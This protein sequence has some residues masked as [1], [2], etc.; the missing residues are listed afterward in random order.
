MNLSIRKK[1]M[2]ALA[3]MLLPLAVLAIAT[4]SVLDQAVDAVEEILVDPIA[5]IDKS[6]RLQ[7]LL[8][9]AEMPANDYLVHGRK[10]ERVEFEKLDRQVE[11]MFDTI[12]LSKGLKKDQRDYVNQA[13]KHWKNARGLSRKI[14]S[15]HTPV[16]NRAAANAMERMDSEFRNANLLMEK[17]HTIAQKELKKGTGL[18]AQVKSNLN[19]T[20]VLAFIFG[21]LAIAILVFLLA[22]SVL[23]P[24]ERLEQGVRAI[25]DGDYAKRVEVRSK[26][27]F[28]SLANAFNNMAAR[29]ATAY[30]NLEQLSLRDG[31]TGILNRRAL[32]DALASESARAMRFGEKYSL[33]MFDID[34][35][36]RV[37]DD[38]GHLFGDDVLIALTAAVDKQIRPVDQFGRYGGEEF[39]VIMPETDNK[40]AAKSAERL[41]KKIEMMKLKD[42]QGNTVPVSA[43]FGVAS[44]PGEA[45]SANELLELADKRLYFAKDSGRNKVVSEG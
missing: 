20:I 31:L 6:M 16:G 34:H 45:D 41:R 12:L 5:D 36:K 29:L 44:F 40:A 13:Y 30:S 43:S 42:E 39:V 4:F 21:L 7:G 11:D 19:Q 22:Q 26:D 2:L 1:L 27:E 8:F 28:G 32:E 24:V 23:Q 35:F 14:L 18:V 38:H 37:N 15:L 25:A 10:S 17:V 9:K 3:G 33:L